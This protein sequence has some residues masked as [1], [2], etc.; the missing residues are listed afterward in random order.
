MY[1]FRTKLLFC[2]MVTLAVPLGSAVIGYDYFRERQNSL[3]TAALIESSLSVMLDIHRLESVFLFQEQRNVQFFETGENEV[4]AEHT[5]HYAELVQHLDELEPRLED[6]PELEKLIQQ[7]DADLASYHNIFT[8]ISDMLFVRGFQDNGQVGKMRGIIHEMET[9][10]VDPEPA[11]GVDLLMIRRHE[12]DYIIRNQQQYRD[13]LESRANSFAVNIASSDLPET[14]KAWLLS[15]L[16]DYVR[17]FIT[18]VEFDTAIG[19]RD[20]SGLYA[21]LDAS[22]S[23]IQEELDNL[24]TLYNESLTTRFDRNNQQG[25]LVVAIVFA[26]SA[27]FIIFLSL[28]LSSPLRA[29]SADIRHF[30]KSGFSDPK[31]VKAIPNE[32]DEVGQIARD[33]EVL[34]HKMMEY[35]SSI[36][37]EKAKADSANQ[38]K[39]VFLANMS[40]EIRTPLNGVAGASQLLS[41]TKL[42]DEQREF[43]EI[44]ADSSKNLMVIVNDILDFSKIEAGKTEL[45]QENFDLIDSSRHLAE[46]FKAEASEK[47]LALISDFS[48][49][50]YN[51]VRGDK[52]KWAQVV[53]N[54]LSNAVKFTE[55]G[56]VTFTVS[57]HR[58][59]ERVHILA[60]VE[61][62]GIGIPRDMIKR[63]FDPFRQED[64]STTRKYGGT[65]LG[66]SISSE[67]ARLMGGNIEATSVDG[68]GSTFTFNSYMDAAT[69]VRSSTEDIAPHRTLKVLLAEDNRLNQK[70]AQ[71]MLR[72]MNCEVTIA[73]NGEQAIQKFAQDRYDL[74]LMDVQMPTMDGLDA[75]REI[76]LLENG[77]QATPIIALT[78]NATEQDRETCFD[79]GMQDFL[80]KPISMAKL[81]QVISR[82]AQ[83]IRAA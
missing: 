32:K 67:L 15:S 63:I 2:F 22:R 18:L 73:E 81:D 54:L 41:S 55:S 16:D 61:D 48:G 45:E 29:L 78:A 21:E 27:G 34:Q 1:S 12:K 38:A 52:T 51:F 10:V 56:Q 6:E 33:F 14:E 64:A 9:R 13:L 19:L 76:R 39:S 80:T 44:I 47:K 65:G 23:L 25:W 50:A 17:E 66:L 79:A 77:Q 7:L 3:A 30:V 26:L 31:P 74:I 42:T 70:I 43:A 8:E 72:K 5:L 53:R 46:S 83:D 4:L 59:N 40:H 28:S 68:Q 58:I 71:A 57:T 11:L 35:V 37:E 82:H 69:E 60:A 49:I 36:Q 24:S 75:T 62:T 20:G